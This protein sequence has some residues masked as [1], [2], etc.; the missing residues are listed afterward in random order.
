MNLTG[1]HY[2]HT[3]Q[4]NCQSEEQSICSGQGC[5]YLVHPNTVGHRSFIL[6]LASHSVQTLNTMLLANNEELESPANNNSTSF[7]P[8]SEKWKKS[9]LIK[10]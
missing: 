3:E 6:S 7:G 10:L 4:K 5:N 8:F 9:N 2:L 1:E